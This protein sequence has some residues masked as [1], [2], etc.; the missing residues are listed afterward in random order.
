[1]LT[2]NGTFPELKI[3]RLNVG[4]P[5][6]CS[7]SQLFLNRLQLLE[8]LDLYCRPFDRSFVITFASSHP[9]LRS[10]SLSLSNLGLAQDLDFLERHP[11]IEVLELDINQPFHC[12]DTS[13]PNLKALSIDQS[14]VLDYPAFVFSTAR[15]TIKQ[16]RLIDMPIFRTGM[17]RDV[18]LGMAVSL[19]CLEMD[20]GM[21][22]DF[23]FRLR[24]MKELFHLVPNLLE[25]GMMGRSSA[26]DN[27][28]PT[29]GAQDLVSQSYL[30]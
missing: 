15:R 16:L 12:N 28:I 14:I 26:L 3:F 9:H 29:F 22:E 8:R 2:R 20:F 6:A 30:T 17:V 4:D 21:F 1:L 23:Q 13:L 27:I 10:L 18:I 24:D 11:T 5:Q 19:T 7:H 25:F